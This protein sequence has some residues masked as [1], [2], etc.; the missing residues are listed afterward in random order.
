MD[1]YVYVKEIGEGKWGGKGGFTL[2]LHVHSQ[3]ASATEIRL[4][5]IDRQNQTY[6]LSS[7]PIIFSVAKASD[8]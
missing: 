8:F 4:K 6:F 3:F 5:K 7:Y 1:V 2:W